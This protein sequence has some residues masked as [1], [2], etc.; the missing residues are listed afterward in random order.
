MYFHKAVLLGV[1]YGLNTTE[2]DL[3]MH[4]DCLNMS[5]WRLLHCYVITDLKFTI[6]T[7]ILLYQTL[8]LKHDELAIGIE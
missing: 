6:T 2:A 8:V 5:E 4:E 7:F 3:T 1:S